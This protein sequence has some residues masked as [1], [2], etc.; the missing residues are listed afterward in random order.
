MVVSTHDAVVCW[1][2]TTWY[3]FLVHPV[4]HNRSNNGCCVYYP[5]WYD[6]YKTIFLLERVP[7]EEAIADYLS[8]T[9][10]KLVLA[11]A[12]QLV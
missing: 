5:V 9:L 11:C 7:H 3:S 6:A 10:V 1:I 12:L 8:L 2:D 4:F